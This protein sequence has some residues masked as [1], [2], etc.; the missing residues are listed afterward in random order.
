[1]W[2]Q[3][4]FDRFV[5]E[6]VEID[7]KKTLSLWEIT[8][9]RQLIDEC[10][11]LVFRDQFLDIGRWVADMKID[12]HLVDVIYELVDDHGH[13]KLSINEFSTILFSWRHTRGFRHS[14]IQ[15]SVGHYEI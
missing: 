2:S 6:V 10:G 7:L 12:P 11:V 15:L 3:I 1:M 4:L 5:G 9:F 8:K 14:R 13:G